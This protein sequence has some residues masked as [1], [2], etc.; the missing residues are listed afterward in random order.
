MRYEWIIVGCVAL[1]GCKN[2]AAATSTATSAD[3]ANRLAALSPN[4]ATADKKMFAS[5]CDGF[6]Q[7]QRSCVAAAHVAADLDKC[8]KLH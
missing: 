3:C 5:V 7:E 1:V 6:T 2:S 4:P 8:G